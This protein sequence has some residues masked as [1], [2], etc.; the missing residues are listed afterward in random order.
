MANRILTDLIDQVENYLH[1][2]VCK[3]TISLQEA[4]TEIAT[5]WLAVYNQMGK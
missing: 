5:N 4:Q 3:G 1:D 2:Q